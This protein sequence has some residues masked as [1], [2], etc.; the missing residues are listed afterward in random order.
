MTA[1]QG[2]AIPSFP[3]FRWN[4]GFQVEPENGSS[5]G[6]TEGAKVKRLWV[7]KFPKIPPRSPRIRVKINSL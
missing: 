4:S 1:L 3:S 2:V 6:I 7:P 5:S